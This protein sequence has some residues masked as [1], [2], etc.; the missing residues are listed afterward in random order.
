MERKT[1]STLPMSP[2][3]LIPKLPN[4]KLLQETERKCKLKQVENYTETSSSI[5]SLWGK[6]GRQSQQSSHITSYQ[7]QKKNVGGT[8]N[9]QLEGINLAHKNAQTSNLASLRPQSSQHVQAELSN[10]QLDW[11]CERL[12]MNKHR[13]FIFV[14]R[15]MTFYKV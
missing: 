9:S 2:D 6:Y 14:N 10:C 1:R 12:N 3:K 11:T 13:R 4:L 5:T 15:T 7:V 8:L